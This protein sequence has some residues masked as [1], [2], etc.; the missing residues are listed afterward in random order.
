MMKAFKHIAL[1]LFI[2]SALACSSMAQP[3][4]QMGGQLSTPN[5]LE[6]Q[7]GRKEPERPVERKK[8]DDRGGRG[9]REGSKREEGGKKGKR[10]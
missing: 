2:S 1:T 3:A 6:P 5:Q 4:N 7:K 9:D 8:N 10:P